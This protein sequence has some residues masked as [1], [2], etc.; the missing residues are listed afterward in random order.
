M[1]NPNS[2]EAQNPFLA[3]YQGS[4]R[5]SQVP[6]ASAPVDLSPIAAAGLPASPSFGAT[7]SQSSSASANARKSQILAISDMGN[8][9]KP[10][11]F[12]TTTPTVEG[13][14]I[15]EYLGMV[16]I[17]IVVPKDVLFR[18]PAPHGDLHRLKAAEDELQRVKVIAL[19]ELSQRAR[20]MGA[21]GIVG[22]TLQFSQ[23]DAIVCLC[24]AVGTAV[25]LAE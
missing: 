1:P 17:E 4:N 16:S 6:P 11:F 12:L 10:E 19:E 2:P 15:Q 20:S 22:M 3:P 14:T 9:N 13:F 7:P 18:N 21:D 24:S 25:K 23:F 8:L 5:N